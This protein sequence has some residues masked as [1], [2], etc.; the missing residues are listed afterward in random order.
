MNVLLLVM[1]MIA[2]VGIN[3][4]RGGIWLWLSLPCY[5]VLALAGVVGAL[6][7]GRSPSSQGRVTPC[8]VATVAFVGYI[9]IRT[10]SSP[11]EY[12]ARNDLFTVIGASILYL[13]VALHLCSANMRG[14]C[15]AVLLIL[16]TA[17][18]VIGAI[19]FTEGDNFMPLPGLSRESYGTRASGFM[20]SPNHLAG[21]L[22]VALMFGLAMTF[23]SRWRI[24]AKVLLG[25]GSL[26]CIA[27]IILTGS[28]G[29]YISAATGLLVFGVLSFL[30]LARQRFDRL[31]YVF[32]AV[33]VV[34]AIG[35]LS[36]A[37]L[38]AESDTLLL[39]VQTA[40][41]LDSA[42]MSIWPAAIQQF[43]LSP[44]FGTG[45]GTF[46][47][48]GRQFRDPLVQT[49]PR[50]AHNDYLQLLAEFGIVGIAVFL[51]FFLFHIRSGWRAL[52]DF[53]TRRNPFDGFGDTAM[54][55]TVGALSALAAMTVHSVVDFNMHIPANAILMAFV[56]GI[57]ASPAV[58]S[59][60][61]A[62]PPSRLDRVFARLV[63]PALGLWILIAGWPK[64][65]AEY[66]AHQ[67]R[68]A[69]AD[70][71][72]LDTGEYAVRAETSARRGLKRD[73]QNIDL[74]N[75]LGEALAARA[76]L[77]EGPERERLYLE[78]A[79]AYRAALQL[80]P[81][82]RDIL[83]GLA[84]SLDPLERFEE[85]EPLFRRAVEL[86]PNSG[87][88]RWAYAAHLHRRGRLDEAE[89]EYQKA[90]SLG[91]GNAQRAMQRLEEERKTGQQPP[92]LRTTP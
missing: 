39:R 9:L 41:T 25:Y 77:A 85:S 51:V 34:L 87:Y 49:D 79:A 52:D 11:V 86:D 81:L 21:F 30:I 72:T 40:T 60:D 42:R 62:N 31:G 18:C 56:F 59:D 70:W 50:F 13:I 48:Y 7:Y 76:A 71:T 80:A 43:Q 89:A 82:D 69:L 53:I 22:E 57:L 27:G 44:V 17:N 74:L 4:L 33:A 15:V 54:A 68:L 14:T 2:V 61:S 66:H 83:I 75:Y 37:F 45:A 65:F 46:L 35:G 20:G 73:P 29:G 26:V 8:V 84:W 47:Y 58:P 16:A 19:Q 3:M 36:A 64:A 23:W 24:W 92:P 91:S 88:V 6:H 78:S 1:V 12:L 90:S 28:R 38:L 32:G 63:V 67:T 10:I 5:A 55:L